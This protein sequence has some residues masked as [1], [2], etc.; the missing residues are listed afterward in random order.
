MDCGGEA[1]GSAADSE[2]QRGGV[3]LHPAAS[4]WAGDTPC[5]CDPKGAACAES[6]RI[7][8]SLQTKAAT[9]GIDI[10]PASLLFAAEIKAFLGVQLHFLDDGDVSDPEDQQD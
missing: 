2:D 9:P 10:A 1:R 3:H 6:C 7:W 5:R 4:R 8:I